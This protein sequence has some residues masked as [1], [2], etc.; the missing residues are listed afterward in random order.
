MIKSKEELK[1]ALSEYQKELEEKYNEGFLR[2]NYPIQILN[3]K[4]DT[5]GSTDGT[6]IETSVLEEYIRKAKEAGATIITIDPQIYGS[7]YDF[8]GNQ[9]N[10]TN[11]RQEME[12]EYQKRLRG[13]KNYII[14]TEKIRKEQVLQKEL[15]E[16]LSYEKIK[17]Q[18]ALDN[19]AKNPTKP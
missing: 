14:T 4:S 5:L 10:Y 18:L 3:D 2:E 12:E 15:Q 16:Y 1:Q 9:F 17:N 19:F 13:Q 6:T 11:T 8:E 7:D